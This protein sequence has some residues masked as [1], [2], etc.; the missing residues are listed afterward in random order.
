MT[1]VCHNNLLMKQLNLIMI[2][3]FVFLPVIL[4][5]K[6][7]VLS[8]SFRVIPAIVHTSFYQSSLNR[9]YLVVEILSFA[10]LIC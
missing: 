9:A 7:L 10:A 5:F 4:I 3:C 8:P 6:S 1:A 2:L